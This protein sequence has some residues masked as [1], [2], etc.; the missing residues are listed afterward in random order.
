M[1]TLQQSI[2]DVHPKMHNFKDFVDKGEFN[3]SESYKL[4]SEFQKTAEESSKWRNL[5]NEAYKAK[6]YN[7]ALKYYSKSVA[8]APAN[9]VVLG[10]A[11]GN[12]SAVLL[13]HEEY[14]LCLLDINRALKGPE[15]PDLSK[16]KLVE[17]KQ[18]CW[19][20]LQS[21]NAMKSKLRKVRQRDV[22]IP[23]K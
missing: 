18:K 14:A 7:K 2:L 4:D 16:Q 11:F 20:L 3:Q 9:S 22:I 12:R 6:D 17:R 10:L 5:G 23:L 13:L 19:K 21:E 8:T 1:S 15:L